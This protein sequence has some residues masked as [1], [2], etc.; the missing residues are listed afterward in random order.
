MKLLIAG[1]FFITPKH[2]GQDFFQ[3]DLINIFKNSNLN[4]INLESPIIENN[5]MLKIDKTGPNLRTDEKIIK[6]INELN[7]N[8]VTLANNHILDYGDKGLINTL[9]IC[10]KNDVKTVGA[11]LNLKNASKPLIIELQGKKIGIINF[12]ENEWSTATL[13]TAGANP[14]DIIDN[15]TQIQQT[16]DKADYVI[17]IIHGGH[18]YYNL[19]SPRMQKQYRF[20]AVNGA[21]IIIGHH[22]HCISGYEIYNSVPIFYSLGNF[23]FT[24]DS[25]YDDW[26]L[27]LLLSIEIKDDK[28]SWDIV[29]VKQSRDDFSVTVLHGSEKTEVLNRIKVYSD[30]IC[31]KQSLIKRWD[32][33]IDRKYKSKIWAFSPI[34]MFGNSKFKGLFRRLKCERIFE[35]KNIM[36]VC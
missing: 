8:V 29:P 26:Y 24:L 27:G 2:L 10:W 22:P 9:Q 16:K 20:F 7:I 17:V 19:P 31:E 6:Q 32:E 13:N 14:L 3:K 4:I 21:D 28:I 15:L 12:C 33:F 30:I 11:G 36:Q 5:E 25:K 1:D 18:E 35:K 23:V 34:N